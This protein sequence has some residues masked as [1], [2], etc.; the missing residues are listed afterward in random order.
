M[1]VIVCVRVRRVNPQIYS[2]LEYLIS[3]INI[4]GNSVKKGF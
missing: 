3:F 2:P 4:C 1:Y